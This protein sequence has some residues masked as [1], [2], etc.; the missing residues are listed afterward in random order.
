MDAYAIELAHN[1]NP[2]GST[3]WEA[4]QRHVSIMNA[5]CEG[6]TRRALVDEGFTLH[7]LCWV[8]TPAGARSLV[9]D[10]ELTLARVET[11]W[12][13]WVASIWHGWLPFSDKSDSTDNT[14]SV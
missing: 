6:Y 1:D 3:V 10:G 4:S 14:P 2:H 13:G 5:L 7:R 12:D 8:W 9:L 11:R